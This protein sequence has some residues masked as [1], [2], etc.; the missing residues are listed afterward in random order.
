M[1]IRDSF[2]II[3]TSD[4]KKSLSLLRDEFSVAFKEND[5]FIE[6][7]DTNALQAVIKKLINNDIAIYSV[8]LNKISLEN[9]YMQI[10]GGNVID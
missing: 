10:A 5:L 8:G 6:I 4:S 9:V 3:S 1:C 2:Y 7:E